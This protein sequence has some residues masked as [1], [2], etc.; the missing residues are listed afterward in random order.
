VARPRLVTP[1]ALGALGHRIAASAGTVSIWYGRPD[2]PPGYARR[3]ATEYYAASTIKLALLVAAYQQSDAGSLDLDSTVRIHQDFASVRGGRFRL[4]RG[5]DNDDEPW[6][7]L[8]RP[9]TLRWLARRMIVRSSNLATNLLLERVGLAAAAEALRA[10][11][12][13]GSALRRPIG[14]DAAA[15]AGTSNVVTAADL[16]A[17]LGAVE[18]G[19]A[20]SPAACE[21]LCD[22]LAAQ[23]Y[24]DWIPS[25]LPPGV[26]VGS[27]GGWVDGILHDAALVRPPDAPPYVLVVCTSG[28]SDAAGLIRAVAA[29]SWADRTC[30]A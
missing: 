15:A 18:T 23:E 10:C 7:C 28:A 5:Y 14:D 2:R 8:G 30:L 29:A 19:R 6:Q 20:A 27:K 17:V 16:A 26:W 4:D 13:T 24:R 9:V 21:E 12:A 1:A 3:P 25:G 22:V 11:G